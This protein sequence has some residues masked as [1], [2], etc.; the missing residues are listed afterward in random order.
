VVTKYL[1]IYSA[2]TR[3]NRQREPFSGQ[4]MDDLLNYLDRCVELQYGYLSN[5][6]DNFTWALQLW[7]ELYFFQTNWGACT[8]GRRVFIFAKT[9]ETELTLSELHDFDDP[10][11]HQ[12][13]LGMCCASI[14]EKERG[15]GQWIRNRLCPSAHRESHWY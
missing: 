5:S 3:L 6:L 12:A 14:D 10:D 1:R 15:E 9:S 4:A 13:L 8:N 11:L 7:G 2:P